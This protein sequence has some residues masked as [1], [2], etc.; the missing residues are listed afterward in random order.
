MRH[1][2]EREMKEREEDARARVVFL[3]VVKQQKLW[4]A[5]LLFLA[6]VLEERVGG[7]KNP[8]NGGHTARKWTYTLSSRA[9]CC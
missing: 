9:L 2:V 8:Q 4:A 1:A 6:V 7:F 5:T 3:D